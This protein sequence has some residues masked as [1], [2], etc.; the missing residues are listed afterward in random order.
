[1][2]LRVLGKK[3]GGK[4]GERD[5]G[6]RS[7]GDDGNRGK[8]RDEGQ[9]FPHLNHIACPLPPALPPSLLTCICFSISGALSS[10]REAKYRAFSSAKSASLFTLDAKWEATTSTWNREE[11]GEGGG[12]GEEV[13]GQ[14][15]GWCVRRL[16]PPETPFLPFLLPSLPPSLSCPPACR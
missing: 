13:N 1:M 3:E 10:G 11:G 9:L 7:D 8:D 14:E 4:E 6:W 16:D 5:E 2:S 15:N 12:E